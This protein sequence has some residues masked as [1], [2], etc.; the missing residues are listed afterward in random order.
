LAIVFIISILTAAFWHGLV[1][2]KYIVRSDKIN[3]RVKIVLVTDLHG[4]IFGKNQ[5]NIVKRIKKAM[6]DLI[7]LGGDI[8]DLGASVPKKGAELFLGSLKG[9]APV[10]YVAGN[11]EMVL[12]RKYPQL[13][14]NVEAY[15]ITVL[16]NRAVSLAV[17]GNHIV[18]GG[19]DD[20]GTNR[21]GDSPERK[22]QLEEKWETNIESYFSNLSRPENEG[23]YKIL[24]SHRSEKTD[25]Y[26][27]LPFDLVL[28]GHAHGGQWRIPFL[29]NGFYAPHQGFFPKYAG[30]L[31]RYNDKIHIISRGA[32]V[33][34]VPPLVIPR[35]FNPPEIVEIELNHI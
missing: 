34:L 22:R 21:K 11:H 12:S 26:A 14:K 18:I 17:K 28:S 5:N 31:Y 30:G 9:V 1:T 35:I 27:R 10:Y 33:H 32:S 16:D 7:L 4:H 15:G 24:L 23:K 13:K 25:I 2:R 6:P 3:E 29:L 19:V 20:P 8:Y